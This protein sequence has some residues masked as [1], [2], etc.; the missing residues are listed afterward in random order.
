[1]I[2]DRLR[3][4]ARNAF[5]AYEKVFIDRIV[6]KPG[7]HLDADHFEK[8]LATGDEARIRGYIDDL[9]AARRDLESATIV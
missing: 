1:M 9:K 6:K 3:Q 8:V 2:P 7:W 4:E 5:A